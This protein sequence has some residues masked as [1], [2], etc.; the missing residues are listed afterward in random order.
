[1]VG[2]IDTLTS[3]APTGDDVRHRRIV[4]GVAI[5]AAVAVALGAW[6]VLGPATD[7][8]S[9]TAQS[10]VEAW[11]DADFAT[12]EALRD[13]RAFLRLAGGIEH[14]FELPADASRPYAYFETLAVFDPEVRSFDCVPLTATDTE[15]AG[16]ELLG[17]T[18][19]WKPMEGV[20]ARKLVEEGGEVRGVSCDVAVASRLH[21][22]VGAVAWWEVTELITSDGQIIATSFDNSDPEIRDG[23]VATGAFEVLGALHLFAA[24]HAGYAAACGE[25]AAGATCGDFLAGHLD[26][27]VDA[28]VPFSLDATAEQVSAGSPP[29]V[30]VTAVEAIARGDDA[31]AAAT[32]SPGVLD[33]WLVSFH[34]DAL[35]ASGLGVTPTVHSCRSSGASGWRTST[36]WIPTWQGK[37]ITVACIVTVPDGDH[38]LEATVT[39][40]LISDLMIATETSS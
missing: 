37:S 24:D 22:S 3:D 19:W 23:A 28:Y 30:L 11:L 31:T 25:T 15:R 8:A 16:E 1:M 17:L 4:V 40:G 9:A 39:D 35:D 32:A 6:L 26:G 38:R 12:V 20:G 14:S 33:R 29:A 13:D 34:R 18:N 5:V 7:D 21:D 36:T 2:A 10:D 27:F